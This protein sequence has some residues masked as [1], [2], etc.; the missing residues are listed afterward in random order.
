MKK[1]SVEHNKQQEVVAGISLKTIDIVSEELRLQPI[2]AEDL[3]SIHYNI[4]IEN[5]IDYKMELV[6]VIV[7]I[8]ISVP[9]IKQ[10][11]GRIAVA[12]VFEIENFNNIILL[13]N[14]I[15][16][17]PRDLAI[18]LNSISIST[19]RGVMFG[20]FKGTFLHSAILPVVDPNKFVPIGQ[21][22]MTE[23]NKGQERKNTKRTKDN[24]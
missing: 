2:T 6:A 23:Y 1:K 24:N 4:N 18:M 19:T 5:K 20:Y 9:A 22:E 8:D 3:A 16:D 17:I 14:G 7:S 10:I 21:T 11:L 15:S 13:K 12:C